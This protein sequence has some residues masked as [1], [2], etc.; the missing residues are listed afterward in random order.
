MRLTVI[1]FNL[2]T[3]KAFQEARDL[4][5]EMLHFLVLESAN[6]DG[7]QETLDAYQLRVSDPKNP[8]K[9]KICATNFLEVGIWNSCEVLIFL[10]IVRINLGE[11]RDATAVAIAG[12]QLFTR[13]DKDD[14]NAT[15]DVQ[16]ATIKSLC[17]MI[18]DVW[19]SG[20]VRVMDAERV[21]YSSR[22]VFWSLLQSW[23]YFGNDHQNSLDLLQVSK[24]L[25][26]LVKN[27]GL[28]NVMVDIE[29]REAVG[30][31]TEVICSKLKSSNLGQSMTPADQGRLNSV[32]G[33]LPIRPTRE[34]SFHSCQHLLTDSEK[35]TDQILS[36]EI[37][38]HQ[39][40]ENTFSLRSEIRRFFS[41]MFR[42]RG[43]EKKGH[44][45]SKSIQSGVL[46]SPLASMSGWSERIKQTMMTSGN[47]GTQTARAPP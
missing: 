30:T 27:G 15:Q 7:D 40:S 5:I 16:Q 34:F 17:W 4:L 13:I 6:L 45:R 26:E 14:T 10:A 3:L 9:S 39:R 25:I 32:F 44:K 24:I 20:Q 43:A 21:V 35:K 23:Q 22:I 37:N 41:H 33:F 42:S 36:R 38:K 12:M 18:C 46:S 8:E 28:V 1:K 29:T 47:V 11:Y 31:L 2:R 19:T